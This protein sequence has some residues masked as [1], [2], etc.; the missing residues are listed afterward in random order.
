MVTCITLTLSCQEHVHL[1][2]VTRKKVGGTDK[3]TGTLGGER[4]WYWMTITEDQHRAPKDYTPAAE[5]E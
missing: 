2:I 5:E 3:R 1:A 4:K